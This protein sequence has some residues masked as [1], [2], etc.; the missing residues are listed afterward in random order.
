M[1]DQDT[2]LF[3]KKNTNEIVETKSRK[4]ILKNIVLSASWDELTYINNEG[5]NKTPSFTIT[6]PVIINGE[7]NIIQKASID[8]M[9]YFNNYT[10]AKFSG[11]TYIYAKTSN[12]WQF[13]N[14]KNIKKDDIL[15]KY[16]N[17]NFVEYLVNEINNDY[18]ERIGYKIFHT[19][20]TIIAG[21]FVICSKVDNNYFQI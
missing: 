11:E 14:V 13:L 8:E 17:D 20:P 19:S 9:F 18:K 7:I 15:L 16:E 5:I 10:E 4:L 2:I 1:I 6:N 21:G 3:R 12:K